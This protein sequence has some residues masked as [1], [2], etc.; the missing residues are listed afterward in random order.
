MA[1]PASK[2]SPSQCTSCDQAWL[3]LK[4]PNCVEAAAAAPPAAMPLSTLRR[5]GLEVRLP[6]IV[7]SPFVGYENLIP[8]KRR[9][10]MSREASSIETTTSAIAKMPAAA[11]VG[12]KVYLSEI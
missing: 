10:L 8:A 7:H 3:M 6:V 1:P 9:M 2:G 4:R 5:D 11:A 12:S